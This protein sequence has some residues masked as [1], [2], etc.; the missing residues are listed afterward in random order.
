MLQSDDL[1]RGGTRRVGETLEVRDLWQGLFGPNAWLTITMAA[2]AVA[3][4]FFALAIPE[5]VIQFASLAVVCTALLVVVPLRFY[6]FVQFEPEVIRWRNR[7]AVAQVPTASVKRFAIE[8]YNPR[9]WVP[10]VV[11]DCD[12]KLAGRRRPVRFIATFSYRPSVARV[13]AG[14]VQAWAEEHQ[15]QS[16]LEAERMVWRSSPPRRNR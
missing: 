10:V 5:D 15:I 6:P 9:A 1:R 2:L 7:F 14:E 16:D 3:S 8:N 13:I 4:A 11:A 12:S